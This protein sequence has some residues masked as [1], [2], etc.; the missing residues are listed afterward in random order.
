MNSNIVRGTTRALLEAA[1]STSPLISFELS[2]SWVNS[3]YRHLDF[4]RRMAT[5]SRPPIPKG[6]YE[7]CRIQFLRNVDKAVK[8]FS[9][10]PELILNSE[11]TLSSYVSVGRYTI[12][13]SGAKTVAIKGLT[14]T[15]TYITLN[16]VI[17]LAGEFLPMQIIYTG[18]TTAYHPSGVTL[19]S[20]FCISQNS[21]NWLNEDETLK[22]IDKIIHPHLV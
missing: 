11:Q 17:S 21:K 2:C 3:V 13:F 10:P 1:S 9:I 16:F 18:K 6:L 20:G 14:Q 4:V 19:P 15:Q 5:T 7:E 8:E 22:V 12:S